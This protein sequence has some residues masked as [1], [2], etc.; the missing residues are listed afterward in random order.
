MKTIRVR[1]EYFP[2]ISTGKKNR[3]VRGTHPL[4]EAVSP[5]EI[6]RFSC[7]KEHIPARIVSVRRYR[8]LLPLVLREPA[9]EILPGAKKS[10][11]YRTV[12]SIY[13]KG[14][15]VRGFIVIV[16]ELA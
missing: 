4:F 13:P 14:K 12:R 2:L 1:K 7:E 8:Y 3:E 10:D 15:R 9:H 11:V 6:V 16:F 5:G